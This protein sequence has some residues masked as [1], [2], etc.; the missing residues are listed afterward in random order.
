[1]RKER[2]GR[3]Y[4][5]LAAARQ[6]SCFKPAVD[7]LL[8]VPLQAL[9]E[10]LEHRGSTRQHDVLPTGLRGGKGSILDSTHLVETSPDI[11]GRLLDDGVDDFRQGREEVGRVD[12]GIEEDFG[13]EETLVADIDG[14]FLR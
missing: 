2:V 4:S 11:D 14:V 13:G 8:E 3:A 5:S 7:D 1:M 6:R 12:L 9:A 10:V